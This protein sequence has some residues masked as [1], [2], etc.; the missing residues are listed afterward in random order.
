MRLGLEAGSETTALAIQHGITGVPIDLDALIN[1]GAEA[2]LAPLSAQGLHICQIGAFGFNPL[3]EDS[4]ALT[5]QIAKL[6]Q[7]IPL[8]AAGGC[9]Y[10]TI[11]GGNYHP[12]GFLA[13]DPRHD[14]PSAIDQAAEVL[15]PLAQLAAQH[16]VYL[17]IE[18]YL[19]ALVNSPQ[20]F[21]ALKDKVQSDALR[22]NIDVTSQY[23]YQDILAPMPKVRAICEQ[24][25]GHYGLVHFKDVVLKETF[26][27]HIDLAPLGSSPTDWAEHLALIAPHLPADSWLI[28][29]HIQ[30]AEE[31]AASLAL[32]RHA[33]HQHGIE[34][35]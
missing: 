28:V 29:E 10:I 15:K 35:E 26:H 19:K 17:T 14:D 34:L 12:S 4:D 9:P 2:T 31:A 20:R 25:A 6:E 32:V 7:G 33:A 16:G 18:P 11:T 3:L 30:S 22:C 13:G 1:N 8:A 21:L 5:A 27:I 23:T 24:L